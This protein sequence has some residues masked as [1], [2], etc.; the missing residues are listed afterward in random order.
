MREFTY[1]IT[2]PLGIHARPAGMI[3]KK[4]R[5]YQSRILLSYGGKSAEASRLMAVMGLGI[6][7]GNELRVSVE[8]PD[9]GGAAEAMES[10]FRETL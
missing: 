2:D 10:F 4:A 8:G 5:E 1:T 7:C 3:V 9:E 6:K